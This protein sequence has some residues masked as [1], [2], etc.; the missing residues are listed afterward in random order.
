MNTPHPTVLKSRSVL[1]FLVVAAVLG[2]C[3]GTSLFQDSQPLAAPPASPP[4]DR[5]KVDVQPRPV[6]R[7]PAG[8]VIT[9]KGA[10]GWSDLILHIKPRLGQGDVATAGDTAQ[11]Y[12][13]M[14]RL[15]IL[16]N[17]AA[18]GSGPGRTYRLER[19]ALGHALEARGQWVIATPKATQGVSLGFIGSRVFEE[20]EKM[21]DEVVHLVRP[22][23]LCV[24]D[25]KGIVLR[26]G[27]HVHMPIRHA[28]VVSPRDGK[29]STFV[30]LLDRDRSGGSVVGDGILQ[31][32]E[33]ACQED[34]VLNVK[35][36]R[37]FLGI[38]E[39]DAFALVKLP[40]GKELKCPPEAAKSAA[41][42]TFTPELGRQLEEELLKLA[43]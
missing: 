27:K 37:F 38:P 33:P 41:A 40:P 26:G 32:I 29:V 22:A 25:A 7:I 36:D 2:C 23:N 6:E 17:V 15:T 42:L 1:L 16:A 24:F 31:R 35:G 34:R 14:F 39:K 13:K 3:Y 28:V 11:Y 18:E 21:L 12:T 43:R 30:W 4:V 9:E 20:N 10:E 19:L 8:T 5:G